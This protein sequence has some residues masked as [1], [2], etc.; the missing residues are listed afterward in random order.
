MLT[1][2]PKTH[3]MMAKETRKETDMMR[4]QIEEIREDGKDFAELAKKIPND[5]KR[6]ALRL[7]EGFVLC[8]E[9]HNRKVG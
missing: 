1:I 3:I 7:L 8:A 5:K 4:E 2:V 9:S 6:E